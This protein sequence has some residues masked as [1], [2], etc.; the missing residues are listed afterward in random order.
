M[1]LKKIKQLVINF[2]PVYALVLAIFRPKRF[3]EEYIYA[4]KDYL[5]FF[6]SIGALHDRYSKHMQKL[7]GDDSGALIIIFGRNMNILFLQLWVVLGLLHRAG[8]KKVFALTSKNNPIQNLYLR[9]CKFD[10]VLIEDL[11][12]SSR[13]VDGK[14]LEKTR[15]L[16]TFDDF[17]T[18]ESDGIPYGKMALSTYSRQRATGIVDI[19]NELARAEIFEIL[20]YLIKVKLVAD[21]MY[22]HRNISMAFFAEV[23]MEEYGPLYYSALKM[24]L[25]IIRFSGTVRDDAV[26]LQHMTEESDRTHFSSLSDD[27]WAKLLSYEFTDEMNSELLQNFNDRY[28]NKWDLS[29]RNQADTQI[30]S[31]DQIRADVGIK[32]EDVIG[33]IYSHILYDN[34]FFNGEY[35]FE[36]YAVWLVET[37]KAAC[38]NP[39]VQWF[40]KVHPS[41]LWRGELEYY[42]K[43]KYEE[44]RLIE[45]HVGSLPNN[46]RFIYPDTPYS[47]YSWLQVAD[48]GITVTGTS[49]IELGALGKTVGYEK[50]GFTINSDSSEEYTQKLVTAH[51]LPKPTMNQTMLGK[52]FAHATFCMKPFTLDFLKPKPR[53]GKDKIFA[54]NDLAFLG[55]FSHEHDEL[56]DS[57][58]NFIHWSQE[59]NNVDFLT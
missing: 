8:G 31:P 33:I 24:K 17:K 34:L 7:I 32:K 38:L 20:I 52:R 16:A 47:P 48:I 42:H 53:T 54:S 41:N 44:V 22:K 19:E 49:G 5:L 11:E 27:S 3:R 12:F 6:Q 37:V 55:N 50:I 29:A 10:L 56:P 28:G 58:V 1:L 35:L 30:V 21:E 36:N 46:V 43:G 18:F 4:F 39:D 14:M 9:K 15:Q 59:V 40:I 23:F 26:V 13:D 25:N 2:W 57:I 51:A 45:E